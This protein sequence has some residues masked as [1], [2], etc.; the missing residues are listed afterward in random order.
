MQVFYEEHGI[1]LS[2]LKNWRKQFA[3]PEKVPR[4]KNFIQLKPL[5]QA[6]TDVQYPF[7]EVVSAFGTRVIFHQPV[8]V[9]I[10]KE[11]LTIK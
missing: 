7:A 3:T 1:A 4:R 8:D 10:L 5:K 2:M 6:I 9:P 11:L